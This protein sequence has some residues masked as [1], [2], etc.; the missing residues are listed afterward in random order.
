MGIQ[1]CYEQSVASW[2]REWADDGSDME[3][4]SEEEKSAFSVEMDAVNAEAAEYR[5]QEREDMVSSRLSEGNKFDMD[6]PF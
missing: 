2:S 3:E 6:A 5:K 4:M 1:H